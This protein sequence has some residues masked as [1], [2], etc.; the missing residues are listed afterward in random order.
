MSTP[1]KHAEDALRLTNS[2]TFG[3]QKW[4]ED[5]L[6]LLHLLAGDVVDLVGQMEWSKIQMA[7][8]HRAV[9]IYRSRTEPGAH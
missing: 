6:V 9:E 2:P 5:A 3:D 1:T 7:A 4:C 8:Q